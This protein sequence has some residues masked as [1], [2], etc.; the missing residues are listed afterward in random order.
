M[1]RSTCPPHAVARM[2]RSEIRGL[3][4]SIAIP[5]CAEPVIGRRFAPTRWLH[6]GY[7]GSPRAMTPSIRRRLPRALCLGRLHPPRQIIGEPRERSLQRLAALA[8]GLALL[9]QRLRSRPD[10]DRARYHHHAHLEERAV[11][12]GGGA[13]AGEASGRIA[14]DGGGT[15]EPLLEKM[16]GEIL[17]AGLDAPIV[18]AGDKDKPVGVANLAGEFFQR[19]R[20]L[21][22]AMLLVH[23]VQHPQAD[24]PVVDQ[25][26]LVA[27]LAQALDDELR[28][29]DAHAVRPVRA[30]QHENAMAHGVN[31]PSCPDLI[32]ASILSANGILRG[33]WTTGSSV[34]PAAPAPA[35]NRLKLWYI[36]DHEDKE[37][38]RSSGTRRGLAAQ[39]PERARRIRA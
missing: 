9:R 21:A 35:D 17:Q 23:P 1:T 18:F 12:R 36:I 2:E 4:G 19:R 37:I 29:A 27:T 25:F 8:G 38:D 7:R 14:G 39:Y 10:R 20:R 11:P 13:H 16:I 34:Q 6:P 15:P 26:D 3:A 28:Q 31:A 24:R 22:L 5:D 32:R 30:V 33:S